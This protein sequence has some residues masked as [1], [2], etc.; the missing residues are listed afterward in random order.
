MSKRSFSEKLRE[1]G[2]L[3]TT[4]SPSL[5]RSRH[6]GCNL[7][8][9]RKEKGNKSCTPFEFRLRIPFQ[10]NL[11]LSKIHS[12]IPGK[13]AT[14]KSLCTSWRLPKRE[15]PCLVVVR[16]LCDFLTAVFQMRIKQDAQSFLELNVW[17]SDE[18]ILIGNP[19]RRSNIFLFSA[20]HGFRDCKSHLV[21]DQCFV[22]ISLF[23]KCVANVMEGG[24]GIWR[25]V[26]K[27]GFM[28]HKSLTE[29]N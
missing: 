4:P 23:G 21:L 22:K 6:R 12:K 20:K 17:S 8:G 3:L 1:V 18:N 19:Q 24:G 16:S 9:Y 10:Q 26:T 13:Q 28:D 11:I 5:T 7:R 15:S 29:L 25:V 2:L 27:H 14:T